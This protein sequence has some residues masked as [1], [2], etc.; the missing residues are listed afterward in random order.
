VLPFSFY[1]LCVFTLSLFSAFSSIREI[2]KLNAGWLAL[3]LLLLL[4]LL[5]VVVVV[6]VVLLLLPLYFSS[7]SNQ[8]H[9]FTSKGRDNVVSPLSF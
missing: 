6:V 1:F 9:T 7:Q 2:T 8:S 3:C 4:L 5:V